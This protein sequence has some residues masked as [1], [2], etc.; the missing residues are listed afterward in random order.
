M[1]TPT[2]D[3]LHMGRSSLDLY[4]NDVGTPFVD[5]TSFAAYVGGS[6]TNICVGANRLGIK[7]TLKPSPE[8]DRN[9]LLRRVS[10]DLTG[11][12]PAPTEIDD[13]VAIGDDHQIIIA[14]TAGQSR[15][16]TVALM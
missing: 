15:Q 1:T 13:F 12:P 7:S 2:F 10:L 6:P 16:E 14:R 11:L 8:A 3:S 9:T 5:I 4:S